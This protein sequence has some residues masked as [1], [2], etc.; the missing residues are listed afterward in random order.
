MPTTVEIG[1]FVTPFPDD[2]KI[3]ADCGDG[4]TIGDLVKELASYLQVEPKTLTMMKVFEEG[5]ALALH[6]KES[7][8]D[9]L[10]VRGVRSLAGVPIRID[11]AGKTQPTSFSKELA[12][13]IQEDTMGHYT[14]ELVQ[15][16]LKNLQEECIEEWKYLPKLDPP[17][18]RA[19]TIGLRNILL[20]QQAKFF[21]KYGFQPT[22]KDMAIMQSIFN[23]MQDD[24][25]I[26]D[27]TNK[28]NALIGTDYSWLPPKLLAKQVSQA[29]ASTAAPA[30]GIEAAAA[31]APPPAA[32]P[33]TG[34]VTQGSFE[35][36]TQ[37]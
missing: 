1:L 24:Q 25:D 37:E 21:P 19:Y 14:A 36:E 23:D 5:S 4:A 3:V 33:A 30:A 29:V 18:M 11:V 2:Q 31:P 9:K 22:S 12:V 16:Q 8:S 10:M 20:P 27:N 28:I 6:N 13:Q 35:V 34:G 7:V 17:T 15:L 26:V 32:A